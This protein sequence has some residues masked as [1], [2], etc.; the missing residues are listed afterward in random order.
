MWIFIIRLLRQPCEIAVLLLID[1]ILFHWASPVKYCVAVMTLLLFHWANRVFLQY[2][3][4]K[5]QCVKY[6]HGVTQSPTSQSHLS[7]T[8]RSDR[9]PPVHHT[10]QPCLAG[11][12]PEST[13]RRLGKSPYIECANSESSRI[14]IKS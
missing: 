13:N 9:L 3:D 8:H 11:R 6:T 7:L 14:V 4:N 1:G 12:S 10:F 2:L 5:F